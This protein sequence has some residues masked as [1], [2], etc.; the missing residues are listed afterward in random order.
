MKTIKLTI[1]EDESV[2]IDVSASRMPS[3]SKY[4]KEVLDKKNYFRIPFGRLSM[5]QRRIRMNDLSKVL[6]ANCI[7]RQEYKR[8]DDG[9]LNGNKDLAIDILNLL[10]GVKEVL[11]NKMKIRFSDLESE[12]MEPPTEDGLIDVLNIEKKEHKL[13]IALLGETSS[14]GYNRLKCNLDQVTSKSFPSYYMLT[15]KRPHIESLSFQLLQSNDDDD[16]PL[17]D[18]E[19]VNDIHNSIPQEVGH[20]KNA[21]NEE[22]LLRSLSKNRISI[23]GARIKGDYEYYI[24]L[25]EDKHK[26]KKEVLKKMIIQ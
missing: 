15:K 21:E 18:S 10:S 3:K 23:N 19:E 24:S 11:E 14:C 8:D 17:V 25:L 7:D 13:A 26:E 9:Y 1:E 22:D 2:E 16:Y 4:K 6:L 12:S 5:R 20:E